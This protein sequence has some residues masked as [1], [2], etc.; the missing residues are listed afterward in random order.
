MHCL[1]R[2]C[3]IVDN[4]EGSVV[5]LWCR[6]CNIGKKSQELFEKCPIRNTKFHFG[7]WIWQLHAK[8]AG[9]KFLSC[10]VGCT[11]NSKS[12]QTYVITWYILY[13]DQKKKEIFLAVLSFF[14]VQG[15]F[16]IDLSDPPPG[17]WQGCTPPSRIRSASSLWWSSSA[18]AT[19][20][21]TWCRWST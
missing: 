14:S 12:C 6:K 19:S 1:G 5:L 4:I 7:S 2:L 9:N 17:S 21:I 11:E 8:L 15:E 18:V 13:K 3:Q 20:C 16:S 10:R